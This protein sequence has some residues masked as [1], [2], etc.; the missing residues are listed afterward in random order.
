MQISGKPTPILT[1]RSEGKELVTNYAITVGEDGTLT[2]P[3]AEMNQSGVYVLEASNSAG[4]VE[5]EV[6]LQ[7]QKE[8]DKEQP[9]GG[10]K[11][12]NVKA[13]SLDKFGEYVAGNHSNNNQG[14]KVQFEVSN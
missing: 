5:R 12:V 14:F 2:F 11:S 3:S 8:W 1:W 9:N 6:K 7:V 10:A 13:V 4:R